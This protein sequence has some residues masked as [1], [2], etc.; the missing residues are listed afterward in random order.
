MSTRGSTKIR[1]IRVGEYLTEYL[2]SGNGSNNLCVD[3]S[4]TPVVFSVSPPPGQ[5]LEV[6]RFLLYMRGTA[7]FDD[8]KFMHLDAL[9]NGIE[10]KINSQL[11]TTWLDNID[12]IIDM[13]DLTSAGIAFGRERLA[14]TGRWSLTKVLGGEGVLCPEGQSVQAIVQD[15]LAGT[16]LFRIK[17]QG[18]L[19]DA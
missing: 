2:R 17:V 18:E 12:I 9:T 19:R 4:V 13:F 14:L 3:G 8:T 16:G 11:I 10:I 15:N 6:G 7:N 1:A 5:H